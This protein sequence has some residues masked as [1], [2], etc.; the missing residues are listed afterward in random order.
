MNT[1][2]AIKYEKDS[3]NSFPQSHDPVSSVQRAVVSIHI[4]NREKP[5]NGGTPK[6]TPLRA[7]ESDGSQTDSTKDTP[8]D[9]PAQIPRL[10]TY[11]NNF[12]SENLTEERLVKSSEKY[13]NLEDHDKSEVISITNSNMSFSQHFSK[14]DFETP[15]KDS[16]ES[17]GKL[18]GI[19]F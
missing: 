3:I 6:I 18:I 4:P 13:E 19:I 14:F 11:K 5:K 8:V 1:F 7:K 16:S 9:P 12:I 15:P 2:E 17:E 10:Q